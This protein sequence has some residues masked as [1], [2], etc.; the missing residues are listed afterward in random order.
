[1]KQLA[2][3]YARNQE[4]IISE[5]KRKNDVAEKIALSPREI[6][7]LGEMHKG[8]SNSEIAAELSLSIN[9]VKMHI[10]GIYNK[11]GA[12]NKADVFRIAAENNL[13]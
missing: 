13:L 9:T 5:Y 10:S 8:F 4:I 3:A 2:S 1:M 6:E 7:I 12:R 11:T